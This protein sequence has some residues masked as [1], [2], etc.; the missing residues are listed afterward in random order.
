MIMDD[1]RRRALL[2]VIAVN[3]ACA[4][5]S[6]VDDGVT[7]SWVVYPLVLLGAVW[8]VLRGSGAL[9]LAVASTIFWLVHLPWT[10]AALSGAEQNPLDRQSPSSPIQWLVTLCVVPLG[11]AAF[12]WWVWRDRRLQSARPA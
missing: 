6:W 7:P 8:R 12:A 5:V 10:W 2:A 1:D 9:Y 11:T 4:P 3:L